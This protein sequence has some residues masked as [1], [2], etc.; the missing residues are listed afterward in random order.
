MMMMLDVPAVH[1]LPGCELGCAGD[2]TLLLIACTFVWLLSW[3]VHDQVGFNHLTPSLSTAFEEGFPNAW[4]K[5]DRK[6]S[7]SSIVWTV[8]D[9]TRS[10]LPVR[11][12]AW[13]RITWVSSR[14]AFRYDPAKT[15]LWCWRLW[16]EKRF[17]SSIIWSSGITLTSLSNL[18]VSVI[19]DSVD[20]VG[21]DICSPLLGS[22]LGWSYGSGW[23][24]GDKELLWLG[25]TGQRGD[26]VQLFGILC[27]WPA[28]KVGPS[29]GGPLVPKSEWVIPWWIGI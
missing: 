26:P 10:T 28:L 5:A 21:G 16:L 25:V 14:R 11:L 15:N 29:V 4:L 9:K 27:N 2:Q 12:L 1:H 17:R 20:K 24:P 3:M 8:L 18:I 13:V 23:D 7:P 22:D 6:L 19:D